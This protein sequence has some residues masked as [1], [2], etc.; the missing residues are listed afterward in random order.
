FHGIRKRLQRAPTILVWV[1]EIQN[2]AIFWRAPGRLVGIGKEAH[3]RTGAD[4]DQ[5]LRPFHELDDLFSEI[6]N[7]LDLDAPGA[8]LATRGKRVAGDPCAGRRGNTVG[9]LESA[10]LQPS[11]ADQYHGLAAASECCC[12]LID[13]LG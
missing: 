6:G 2:P 5:L 1:R 10:F 13:G 4:Q 11:P 3:W 7:T 9:R 8:A 12:G